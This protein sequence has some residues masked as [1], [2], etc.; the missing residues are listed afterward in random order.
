[1]VDLSVRVPDLRTSHYTEGPRSSYQSP[2]STEQTDRA[3]R[4]FGARPSRLN[5]WRRYGLA[6]LLAQVFTFHM[7]FARGLRSSAATARHRSCPCQ[8]VPLR[9]GG[10]RL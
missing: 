1:M 8:T 2:V 10:Q 3:H 6:G 4:I 5:S 9:G 7:G